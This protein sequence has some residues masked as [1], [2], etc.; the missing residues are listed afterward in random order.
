MTPTGSTVPEVCVQPH[1]LSPAL[2]TCLLGSLASVVQSLLG[3]TAA[4]VLTIPHSTLWEVA[5]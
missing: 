5:S 4:V 2:G 3:Q 1:K